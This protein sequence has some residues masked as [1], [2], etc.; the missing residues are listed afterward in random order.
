MDESPY[1][2]RRL[3]VLRA[4]CTGQP[5]EMVNLFCVPMKNMNTSTRI[6]KALERLRQRYGVSG[7]LTTE[8][9]V[10]AVRNGPKV[11]H[12]LNSMKI[13]NEDLNTLE[14][15]AFAHDEVDKLSGQL[16]LDTASRLP[17]T[18]KRRYLDY[19]NKKGLNL[20]HPGLDSLRDFVVNEIK[21]MSSDYAQAF[22]GSDVKEVKTLRSKNYNVHQV[23]VDT[24]SN[25][26]GMTKESS[27]RTGRDIEK[28]T[29]ST[30]EKS[31]NYKRSKEKSPP[32]CFVCA[33]SD[34]KH[35]LGECEKFKTYLKINGRSCLMLG[36]V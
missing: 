23:N 31:L 7:G 2:E 9:K 3:E 13:F 12:D 21:T 14:I 24:E 36:D 10:K 1:D 6:E 11:S 34:V 17:N 16:L 30:N 29:N 20:S 19:L 33:R 28:K 15:F 18:L 5:R 27:L 35:F 22:F 4:S 32:C 8:P 25:S 26:K